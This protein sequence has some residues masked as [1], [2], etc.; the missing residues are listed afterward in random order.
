MI[1]E[2][3]RG[4]RFALIPDQTL[5]KTCYYW[6]GNIP[7]SVRGSAPRSIAQLNPLTSQ[8]PSDDPKTSDQ[9]RVRWGMPGRFDLP[10]CS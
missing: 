5:T 8:R 9:P 4:S 3:A 1:I 2:P 7:G 10:H 6:P